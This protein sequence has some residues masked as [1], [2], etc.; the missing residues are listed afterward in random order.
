MKAAILIV[1]ALCSSVACADEYGYQT[2]P[3]F[4]RARD[5]AAAISRHQPYPTA[6]RRSN[7]SHPGNIRSHVLAEHSRDVDPAWIAAQSDASLRAFHSDHHEGRVQWQ[8]VTRA[9]SAAKP[10]AVQACPGGV[11]PASR[12]GILGRIF[13]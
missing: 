4:Y 10:R 11:C 6:H 12:P 7:W 13:R 8:F 3:S 2:V 9:T 1:V 5:V